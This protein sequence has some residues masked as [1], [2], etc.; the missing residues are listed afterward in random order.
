MIIRA[1]E[2]SPK[3]VVA[4]RVGGPNSQ[5]PAHPVLEVSAGIVPGNA[6]QSTGAIAGVKKAASQAERRP[7]RALYSKLGL[8]A[9]IERTVIE[10]VLRRNV[11]GRRVERHGLL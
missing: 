9:G 5:P 8:R 3:G 10:V 1:A 4:E 7:E 11:R 6:V 2:Y